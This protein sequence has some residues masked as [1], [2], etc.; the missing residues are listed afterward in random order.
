VKL[1]T[2]KTD[3]FIFLLIGGL[4][5]YV[6]SRAALIDITHD[7]AYSFYNMKK[8]WYAEALCTGNTHWL[9]SAA[10]KIAILLK[11]ETLFA[12]RWL[13]ILSSFVFFALT[14]LWIRSVK[15]THFKFLI[16]SILLLN[17]YIL[18][19]FSMA[20]GYAP[21]LMFQALA[22]FYFTRAV[23]S[24][25]SNSRSLSLLFAGVSPLS[26]FSYIYFLLAFCLVYYS[27]FYFKNGISFWKD[28][29]F[30]RD[31]FYILGISAVVIRA[32]MFMT[33]CSNDV[34][35]A[36]TPLLSEY[37]H[38]FT[39]G[40]I[41]RKFPASVEAL[42][43]LALFVFFFIAVS[44][45]TGIFGRKKHGN[46]IY[47]YVSCMLMVILGVTFINY[48]GFNLVLPYYRSAIFLFPTTA[49]CFIFFVQHVLKKETIKKV[50]MYFTSAILAINFILSINFK[51]VFDFYIQANLKD[52]FDVV[53]REGGRNIGISPEL[54]G[55]FRNYY[56]MTEKY[57]YNFKGEQI[58]T[59]LPK[60]L[61][62]NPNK[63]SEF[64]YIILF[65][66]YDFSYYKNNKVEFKGLKVFPET[67]TVVLKLVK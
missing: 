42:N 35:G 50:M 25:G 46:A 61:G 8:F 7:E 39:D 66:P 28:R 4:F 58:N 13:S 23:K 43:L 47:F 67:G 14:F 44:G 65:P 32:F 6:A 53:E 59:N 64:D 56:Q 55:G 57:R 29:K 19:Y 5:V 26:N 20:R 34:V 3:A 1:L 51:W 62:T 49:V 27:Y 31:S 2:T 41:Y 17:P 37:F 48:F 15:E 52:S 18:D 10:I 22:L 63:L 12:I 30:Y 24:Q 45:L 60:G 21:G 40:L 38:V 11:Q 54:Y 9:N 16:F 33:K 36:G